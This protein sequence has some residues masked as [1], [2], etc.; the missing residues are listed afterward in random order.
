MRVKEMIEGVGVKEREAGS[1]VG[2]KSRKNGRRGEKW[3]EPSGRPRVKGSGVSQI[4][5]HISTCNK[6]A[7]HATF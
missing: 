6:R 1:R 4:S 5:G 7:E 3:N 2:G